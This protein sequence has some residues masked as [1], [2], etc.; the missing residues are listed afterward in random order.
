[1]AHTAFPYP[2]GKST[3]AS[4][5]V[6]SLPE[7]SAY[8]E[9]FGGSGAVLMNKEPS[10]IEVYNDFDGDIPQFFRILR[11]RGEELQEYLRDVEF[12][13]ELY[14]EWTKRWYRGWRP[15]DPVERAAV[16]YFS[17][18]AQWG[19]KYEGISG[20][21][22]SSKGRCKAK[23]WRS[24]VEKL[25]VFQERLNDCAPGEWPEEF[26]AVKERHRG[27]LIDNLD[28][29]EV[30]EK[31]DRDNSEGNGTVFYCDPPYVD[32]EHRYS[33][34]GFDHEAFVEELLALEGDWMVSY[35]TEVPEGLESFR[36]ESEEATRGIDRVDGRSGKKAHER[37]IKS[38]PKQKERSFAIGGTSGNAMEEDW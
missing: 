35:G 30:F 36:T 33:G 5:I 10:E 21:A 14:E 18:Y 20:F 7:H 19:G 6:S 27:V 2:G 3:N 34:S 4:W 38:Y 26:E 29:R 31:Y 9:V 15:A 16:F 37:L 25:H 23:S 24:K 8:V 1:M 28:Y 13:A 11:D 17:R 22:R 12:S 32:T